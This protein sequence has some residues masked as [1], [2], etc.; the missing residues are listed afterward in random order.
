VKKILIITYGY[1]NF[2]GQ[3]TT[4]YNLMKLLNENNFAA[5]TIYI[6]DNHQANID[7]HDTGDTHKI[8]L[9][10]NV[11]HS[12]YNFYRKKKI[13]F[14]STQIP[15][16]RKFYFL[17]RVV[18][19]VKIFILKK[20]F[21]PDLVITNVPNYNDWVSKLFNKT[22]VIIGSS[23]Y[24]GDLAIAGVD[25]QSFLQ[26]P[27]LI[28]KH[29]F[30]NHIT[31]FGNS[32]VIF[33]SKLTQHVY[34]MLGSKSEKDQYQYFN[35]APYIKTNSQSFFERKYDITFICSDFKRVIKNPTL[36]AEFFAIFSECKKIAIGVGSAIFD[37]IPN[38][39]TENLTSQEDIANVLSQSKL[40]IIPSYFDS[41]PSVLSE[42]V[43]NG[44]N[45]LISKNVGWYEQIDEYSVVQNYY[46]KKEWKEKIDF[47]LKNKIEHPAFVDE[48]S[49]AKSEILNTIN[50][51]VA[52][53]KKH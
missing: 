28:K 16:I 14:L 48:M 15:F 35:F 23:P 50:L 47:L 18:M 34:K 1:P 7:P 51:L 36:A 37:E 38:T 42:A 13:K 6:I 45:V 27:E 12:V 17:I 31:N 3:A 46:D 53:K 20:Q 8:V 41:S 9:K 49:K 2:G 26:N 32:F 25:T 40:V 22:A 21:Q 52:N 19:K 29:L 39:E 10:K 30:K 33:N 44:C 5:K 4:A 43:L 11:I 24:S